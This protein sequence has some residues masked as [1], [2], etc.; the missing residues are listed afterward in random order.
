MISWIVALSVTNVSKKGV[1][2]FSNV[3]LTT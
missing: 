1:L 3:A 2:V